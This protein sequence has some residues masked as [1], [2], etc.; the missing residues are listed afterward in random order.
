MTGWGAWCCRRLSVMLGSLSGTRGSRNVPAVP[1]DIIKAREI[2]NADALLVL[3][4]RPLGFPKESRFCSC[5][6]MFEVERRVKTTRCCSDGDRDVT[7]ECNFLD[8]P[9]HFR[10]LRVSCTRISTFFPPLPLVAVFLLGDAVVEGGSGWN[11]GGGWLRRGGRD[12]WRWVF[13]MRGQ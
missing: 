4:R 1:G 7:L 3:A 13:G 5:G 8:G 6:V 2:F 12:G 11:S 10:V 9:V